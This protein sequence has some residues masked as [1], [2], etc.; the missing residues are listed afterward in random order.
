MKE[1]EFNEEENLSEEDKIRQENFLLQSKI[2]LKGGIFGDKGIDDPMIENL[3]LKNVM[4]FEEAEFIPVHEVIDI[5]PA[6][7]PDADT[8]TE[9]QAIKYLLSFIEKLDA[10]DMD[11]SIVSDVPPKEIYRFLIEDYFYQETQQVPGMMTHIDGCSGD[12]P[13][14]FQLKYCDA[15]Y[16]VWTDEELEKEIMKRNLED[17]SEN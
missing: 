17:Y 7:Y 5:N 12:C 9:K 10:K 8:L 3:F 4:A 13:S 2:T 15:K 16:D 14:C 11:L 6:D 1:D